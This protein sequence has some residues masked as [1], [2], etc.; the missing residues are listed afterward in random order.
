MSTQAHVG[1][2]DSSDPPFPLDFAAPAAA[3]AARAPE[4]VVWVVVVT[5]GV[6]V[7]ARVTVGCLTVVAGCV[8]VFAGCRHGLRHRLR[9]LRDGFARG[10]GLLVGA[11]GAAAVVLV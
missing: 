1:T 11:G 2:S 3:P 5:V 8:T 7:V 10:G 4:G 9:G 6:T